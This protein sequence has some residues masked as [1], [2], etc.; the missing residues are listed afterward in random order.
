MLIGYYFKLAWISLKKTPLLSILM[1]GT[2]AM[3]IAATMI[4]STVSIMMAKDPLPEKSDRVFSVRLS[5]WSPDKAY[6]LSRGEEMLPPMMTYMD[7]INLLED[8]KG[9]RQSAVVMYKSMV[10]SEE[11]TE[12]EAKML[13]FNS[14]NN[15]FFEIFDV[16]FLFG[17][18]WS[19]SEDKKGAA[20][21]V[22]DKQTNDRLFGGANSV[23]QHIFVGPH[24][25]RVVGVIDSWAP[26]P[27]V[28]QGPNRAHNLP[29]PLFT[30]FQ[31]Q[32][33][34]NLLSKGE[35]GWRCWTV[36]DD[37]SLE[38]FLASECVWI[39]YWVELE[40]A[41]QRDDYTDYINAYAEEQKSGGRFAREKPSELFDI[42]ESLIED[43]VIEDDDRIAVWL[44]FAFLIACLLNCMGLMLIKFYGK[45]AE[46]GLRRAV[47]ASK[48]H[49]A[50]QFG[51]ETVLIGTLG[52]ILG[53]TL[54][55]LGLRLTADTFAHLPEGL[56][57][58]TTALAVL[59]VV[60]AVFSSTLFGL[61]P[62]YRATQIQP[63]AQLKSQ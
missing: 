15:D 44:A 41:T 42:N 24:L 57:Q 36:L 9:L 45:G 29:Y 14:V 17:S 34:N 39:R 38:S 32:V 43:H 2:I 18:P 52:G 10:R 16:P 55:Q 28:F 19:D 5:S 59:T 33:N 1:I 35:M 48:Q 7:T 49:I 51:C 12:K 25:V 61:W 22:L 30:P 21:V 53:L 37:G 63:S 26:L 13:R 8:A 3:G 58:M 50:V 47:G 23:G 20:L 27:Q 60:L 40:H 31:F 56:M 46:V 11:Q 54:A 62:I 6:Q 4:T